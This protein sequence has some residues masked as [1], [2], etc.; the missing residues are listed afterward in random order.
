MSFQSGIFQ[1]NT[2]IIFYMFENLNISTESISNRRP[3][4]IC[5]GRASRVAYPYDT[6]FNSKCFTYN[7]CGICKT[8]FVDPVPDQVTFS[9]M[10]AQ[11]DYHDLFYQEDINLEEYRAS[12]A[13]L[14]KYLK[15][16][17]SVLDYGCGM[18]HFLIALREQGFKPFGVEFDPDVAKAAALRTNCEVVSVEDFMQSTVE[19]PFDAIHLG[20]V[21]EHLPDP[22]HTLSQL[23]SY[24]KP[25]GLLYAQGPLER[26]A[27][28]VFWVR[29]LLGGIKR[30][31]KPS[32]TAKH[33]PTHLYFTGYRQ[34][35]AF[36]SRVSSNLKLQ[37]WE[38]FETGWPYN[39]KGAKQQIAA[40]AKKLGGKTILNATFGNK[41]RGIFT[42]DR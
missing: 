33:P 19:R 15:G 25:N 4:P 26:N 27:S 17:G 40:F 30:H 21:L 3:C 7:L 36:F 11:Q 38:V 10:Y 24:L 12:A 28:P 22:A 8:V 42:L 29:S 18:G 34:Q 31:I 41:F 32:L 9:K 39:T 2:L 13:L 5:G 23:L 20:D 37:H 6:Y 14:R 1:K 16:G 35:L